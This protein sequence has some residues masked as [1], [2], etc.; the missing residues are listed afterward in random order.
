MG[1]PLWLIQRYKFVGVDQSRQIDD[2][3]EAL[4]IVRTV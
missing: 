1:M 2:L 4:A 3:P